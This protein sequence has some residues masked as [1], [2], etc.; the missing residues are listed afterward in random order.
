M[1][2]LTVENF[3]LACHVKIDSPKID[4]AVLILAEKP[5][6]TGPPDYFC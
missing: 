5:A 1:T 2:E 3:V 4:P 6:K